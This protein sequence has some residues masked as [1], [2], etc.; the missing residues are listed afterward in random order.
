MTTKFEIKGKLAEL[1]T[2]LFQS[3]LVAYL[4][5]LLVEQIW[6]GSVAQYINL[7]YVLIA[8][9]VIGVLDVF[10]EHTEKKKEKIAWKDYLF[11]YGLGILGFFIIK[12]KTTEL[13][14]ISWI[15]SIIAGVLIV[16]ISMLVLDEDQEQIEKIKKVYKNKSAL[17]IF[18]ILTAI[19]VLNL[20]SFFISIFSNLTYPES[21]RIVF[22]SIYV[23]FIPG[24]IISFI[25]FPKTKEFN[26]ED[27]ETGGI[28]WTERIALSFALSIAIVPLTIFYLNLLGIKINWLN[29][30]LIILGIILIS[31]G[32]LYFRN[33]KKH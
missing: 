20:I 7:N 23:L 29:S 12:F 5:L 10:S 6:A 28:D 8:V 9:I 21:L 15:I 30:S 32:I 27:K 17:R 25:F 18:G 11:I 16:L 3:L 19:L 1:A 26:S 14:W 24:L 22:G 13:G 4:V 2:Y 31:S 33:K